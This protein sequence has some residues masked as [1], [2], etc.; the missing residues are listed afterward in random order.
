MTV[1]TPVFVFADDPVT[2]A[3][4]EQLL[5]GRPEVRVVGS[6]QI[7]DADVAIVASAAVDEA[8][9]RTITGIQRDGCPRVVVVVQDLDE[10][11]ILAATEAGALG[12]LRRQDATAEELARVV[13]KVAAGTACIPTD[14]VG[15]L[16]SAVR[17]LRRT[18]D[19]ATATVPLR[20]S[21]REQEVLRLL[22]D[23]HDTQEIADRL[24]YSERTVKGVIHEITTRLHL[25]NRSHAV[26]FALRHD[27]I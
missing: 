18:H 13:T 5:R 7:D 22:A 3:G 17:R 6:G 1:R 9:V 12:M 25:R 26:A 2:Q 14:L 8:M 19:G 15:E 4:L 24:N 16:L 10:S 11:G 20:L 27:L 21:E 23:G